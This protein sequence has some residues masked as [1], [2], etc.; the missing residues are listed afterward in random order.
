MTPP[1]RLAAAI[2]VMAEIAARRRPAADALKDWGLSHR[3]AGAGD[4]SAIGGLVYDALRAKASSAWLMGDESARG[5][6]LG[7]L[8]RT[9]GL[10]VE[11]IARLCSGERYAPA[12]LSEAESARLAAAS[13]DGAPID[14]R[15]DIPDWLAPAFLEAFGGEAEAEGR[16]LSERAPIDLRVNTLKTSRDAALLKLAHLNARPTPHSPVGLRIVVG[17]DG[18]APALHAEPAYIKGLVEIQD[19]GSQVAALLSGARAGMQILDL[20]AGGGG[21]SLALAAMMENHGQIYATDSDARRLAPIHERLKRAGVH[22]VQVRSPRKGV[23]VVADLERRCD[24]VLVDAPCS[25]SGAW[26]RNPDAKWRFRPNALALRLKEQSEALQQGA[27]AV[28]P[29]GRLHYVTCSLFRSE[30][31]DQITAFLERNADFLPID[32]GQLA[33]EAGLL[34]LAPCASR[35][36]AGLRLSP[37]KTGTD[38]FY[39]AAL[40]RI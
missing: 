10:E 12:A 23:D 25:G 11:A 34:D 38:G 40:M 29:R 1:A 9:R 2:E 18:R 20:C 27:R 15:A 14:V 7:A 28:K 5:V 16:A 35:L 22:N 30:N 19:E 37:L 36:G 31:E 33:R 6:L 26:R 8:H 24:L 13:L 17:A 32:A 21:K 39:V 4:R 3:F